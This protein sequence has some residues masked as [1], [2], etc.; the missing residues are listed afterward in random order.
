MNQLQV[1]IIRRVFHDFGI[2]IVNAKP[3]HDLVMNDETLCKFTLPL[4]VDGTPTQKLIWSAQLEVAGTLVRVIMSDVSDDDFCEIV[5]ALSATDLPLY[6]IRLSND[7][8]DEGIFSVRAGNEWVPVTIGIQASVLSG[9]EGLDSIA[10]NWKPC[11]N[12]E[13]LHE[14]LISLMNEGDA[15]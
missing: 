14:A 8:E 4:E 11:E 7:P 10:M 12:T 6:G 15:E 9:I 1:E 3:I 2:S 13:D 5:L